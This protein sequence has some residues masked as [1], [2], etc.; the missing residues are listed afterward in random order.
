MK[1]Y[2]DCNHPLPVHR[3]NATASELFFETGL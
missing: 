1:K 2:L 3:P